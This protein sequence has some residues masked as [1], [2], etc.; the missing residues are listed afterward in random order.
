MLENLSTSKKVVGIRES[1]RA[2]LEGL[3]KCAYVA[4]D[5]EDRVKIPFLEICASNKIE[6]IWIESMSQLGHACGITLGA[7]VA[8]IL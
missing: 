4:R 6:V 5:A 1:T 7:S 2:V 8:V 3:A